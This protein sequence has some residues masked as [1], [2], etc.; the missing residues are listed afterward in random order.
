MFKRNS[1]TGDADSWLSI[2][3]LMAGLMIFFLFIAI[4]YIQP[5]QRTQLN[6]EKIIQ[7]WQEGEADIYDAL[8]TEFEDDLPLWNAELDREQLVLRFNSPEV[9]FQIGESSLR[10]EFEAILS[11]FFPRYLATLHPFYDAGVIEEIRIEG[12]TSSD[13][14]GASEND[15][16][17]LNMALSQGRTRSVLRYAL[18][19]DLVEGNRS[20][21]QPLLTA[22]GLSSSRPVTT[23]ATQTEDS[24]RSRRVEF[25][26]RT[27]TQNRLNEILEEF[28]DQ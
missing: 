5:L 16:Y 17:F 14:S 10:P 6:I 24:E 20:W 22:N 2:S 13:W 12:H 8:L 23:Q 4:L 1:P 21:A 3:D 18:N 9:L 25:R 11:D 7:T 28:D 15:A 27:N 19:L 26:V